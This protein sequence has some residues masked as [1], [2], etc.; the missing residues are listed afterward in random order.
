MVCLFVFFNFNKGEEIEK[1]KKK[2]VSWTNRNGEHSL[3]IRATRAIGPALKPW[4]NSV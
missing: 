2:D 1:K 3:N 4:Q